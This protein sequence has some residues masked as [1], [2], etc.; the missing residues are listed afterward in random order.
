MHFARSC[1]Q[2]EDKDVKQS[3]KLIE[4][5]LTQADTQDLDLIYNIE[6][7]DFEIDNI[8]SVYSAYTTESDTE[9][10]SEEEED[11]QECFVI[12]TIDDYEENIYIDYEEANY[13]CNL[14]EVW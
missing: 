4:V 11:L 13:C 5:M 12:T 9:S 7:S 1:S 3:V 6:L 14:T 2:K 10:S 8:D